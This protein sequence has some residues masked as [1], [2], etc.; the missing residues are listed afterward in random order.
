MAKTIYFVAGEASADNHGAALMRALRNADVDPSTGLRTSLSE[1][2]LLE[3]CRKSLSAWQVTK[4]I[5]VL[6]SIATN[7][8]GKISRR[9]LAKRFHL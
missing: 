6:D 9:D 4:R 7:E 3:F 8:R 2:A 1:S 5:F